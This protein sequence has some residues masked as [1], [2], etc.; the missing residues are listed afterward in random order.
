MK[1]DT[2]SKYAGVPEFRARSTCAVVMLAPE[3]QCVY[4]GASPAAE[5]VCDS[6]DGNPLTVP[7]SR[8]I[9]LS[10]EH[11]PKHAEKLC[12]WLQATAQNGERYEVQHGTN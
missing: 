3:E 4:C 7:V 10:R 5:H 2:S 11:D 9:V 12:A 8:A 1:T 6:A